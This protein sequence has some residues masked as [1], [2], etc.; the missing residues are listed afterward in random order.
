M[1]MAIAKHL[2]KLCFLS[3]LFILASGDGGSIKIKGPKCT[4]ND[5]G[6][7]ES[8]NCGSSVLVNG[9]G[10]TIKLGE[11]C[12]DQN[13]LQISILREELDVDGQYFDLWF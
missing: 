7:D 4:S 13:R 11:L 10:G 1:F 9:E 8:V 6:T 3:A 12:T 5:E 2:K